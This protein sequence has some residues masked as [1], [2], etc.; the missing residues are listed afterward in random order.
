MSER[1]YN[2]PWHVTVFIV[3]CATL[4]VCVLSLR[5]NVL[6]SRRSVV[7]PSGPVMPESAEP[8]RSFNTMPEAA[9]VVA[10]GSFEGPIVEHGQRINVVDG[11]TPIHWS[12]Y[13]LISGGSGGLSSQP[14][15]KPLT[16]EED[17]WRVRTGEQSQCWFW[18]YT[19]GDGAIWRKT[20]VPA[21]LV[22]ASV[23]AHAWVSSKDNEPHV[24]P[25]EM[26]V[27][28]G[29][30]T[31]GRDPGYN[32]PWETS[33]AWSPF[34]L[35]DENWTQIYSR[36][37]YVPNGGEVTIYLRALKKWDEKHGDVYFD[38]WALYSLP[39][40]GEP[41]PTYTPYPTL[42]PAPTYTPYPT[43]TPQ[44]TPV[45]GCTPEPSVFGCEYLVDELNGVA[46]LRCSD[47]YSRLYKD[48]STGEWAC[49]K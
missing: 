3:S 37:A 48:T 49:P 15:Y 32:W 29:I 34:V 27:S 10:S 17:P 33:V 13:P 19:H 24:S 42:T 47:E 18:F 38:D 2:T 28:I 46:L 26:Y 5:L 44:P 14:E 7:L 23:W 20:T 1:S 4:L 25:G 45:P 36:V 16:I 40:D 6:N 35:V 31:E 9:Q 43:Y 30:D 11:W 22:Q 41:Q 39:E 21:G 8:I 12:G